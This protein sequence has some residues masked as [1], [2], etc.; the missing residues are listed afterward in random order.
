M[1]I[2]RV[3]VRNYKGIEHQAFDVGAG[4][5][6]IK[7]KNRSG[8]TSLLDGIMAGLAARGVGP[9][10]IRQ[11]AD[12]AEILILDHA[13]VRRVIRRSGNNELKTDGLGLGKPQSRLDD[14]F[15]D[16]LDPLALLMAKPAD[17][18]KMILEIMPAAVTAEDLKRWTGDDWTPESGKHGLEVI[19]EVRKH[20]YELRTDANKAA[21]AAAD[22]AKAK[23]ERANALVAAAPRES[24]ELEAAEAAVEACEKVLA[25]LDT[26]QRQAE[27]QEKRAEGTRAR[28]AKLRG[29]A[30]EIEARGA[31]VPPLSERNAIEDAL[32][33]HRDRIVEL[34]M[35][36]AEEGELLAAAQRKLDDF[37]VREEAGNRAT[38]AMA[39]KRQQ[40]ADLEASLAS[41]TIAPPTKEE[42]AAAAHAGCQAADALRDAQKA[43]EAKRAT[44]EYQREQGL[45]D[46]AAEK[47]DTLNGIVERLTTEA[48]AELGARAQM[49]PGLAFVDG[50]I[51][52]D[53]KVFGVL[54]DSEK[55]ALCVGVA[56][57][58]NPA[59]KV[60]RVDKLEQIDP[61]TME[62][63]VRVATDGGWQLLG[64]RVERGELQIIAIEATPVRVTI[65]LPPE[66]T[67]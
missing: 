65:E 3:E 23:L 29:E 1:K 46:D 43:D 32:K 50:D 13:S 40:A 9:E 60:L 44:A 19:A 45:A 53:G 38:A 37:H 25:E 12:R 55:I 57:R 8:K 10:C 52:M 21:K 49:I 5:A 7:G 33:S 56:K 64:T 61:D 54:S 26:R 31:V 14:L 42:I 30:E 36:L 4:G 11:G 59:G 24:P 17:R 22:S 39:Q 34:K 62:E 18:Q 15:G 63:F 47:A 28:V 2:T 27:E 51:A 48:P 16:L 41:L 6:I 67:A 66:P 58:A 35:L 20:Y